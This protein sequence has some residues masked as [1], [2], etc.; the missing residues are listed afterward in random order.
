MVDRERVD[1]LLAL[2]Q[3]YVSLLRELAEQP[4]ETVQADPHVRGSAERY[5]Q[6]AIETALNTGHHVIGGLGLRQ[7]AD[8]ADVFRILGEAGILDPDFAA[9]IEPMAGLRNRL[10]HVYWEVDPEQVHTLLRTRLDDFDRF[11]EE[12]T[13]ALERIDTDDRAASDD[14]VDEDQGTQLH[15]RADNDG[16]GG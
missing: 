9:E 2:L 4:L 13:A 8:Y 14:D 3:R 6:L 15:D 12:V 1:G 16:R 7:P 10:V 5:L 11:A